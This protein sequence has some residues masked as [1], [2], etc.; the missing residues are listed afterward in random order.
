MGAL[1]KGD[2]VKNIDMKL[3]HISY[4]VRSTD[5]AVKVFNTFYSKVEI[6]KYLE[7]DQN[8]FITYLSNDNVTH[9]IELVEPAGKPNPVEN[10]LKTTPSVLYHICYRVEDILESVKNLKEKGF[11]MVTEPFEISFEKGVWASHFFNQNWGLIELI[12]R[13]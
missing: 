13:K 5:E 7:K 1:K 3:D 6:Y 12:G 10:M 2:G 8:V 9:R 4:A 11:Y